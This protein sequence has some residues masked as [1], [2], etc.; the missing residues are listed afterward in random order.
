MKKRQPIQY[1]AQNQSYVD[2]FADT[3]PHSRYDPLAESRYHEILAPR[4]RRRSPLGC[5][6]LFFTFTG[7]FMLLLGAYLVLPLRTNILVMGIDARANEADLGRTDTLILSTLVP[8]RLY[9]GALSIPRDLW[10]NVPGY[11]EN[12][13]NTAHFYA[14]I[15]QPGS[16]PEG[17]KQ[18]V[19]Q[20]FGVD[21][22]YFV[23]VRFDGFQ[24][25]VDALGGV[26]VDLPEAMSGYPAGRHRMDG[27]QALA[28]VRDRSGSDDFFRMQRGQIFLK[29]VWRGYDVLGWT[30]QLARGAQN[31]ARGCGYRYTYLAVAAHRP[32][33]AGDWTGQY[34]LAHR[35]PGYGKPFYNLRRS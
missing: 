30:A 19:R 8:Y 33:T 7:L 23:R 16:G 12:R 9:A 6:C 24:Y 4:R 5:G 2:P 25:L 26:N 13:I 1:P 18:V 22:D 20:N 21:V 28:L 14:E 11:G 3:Q 35:Q 17:T 34:R 15:N 10:V 31:A 29:S 32:G 27:Q